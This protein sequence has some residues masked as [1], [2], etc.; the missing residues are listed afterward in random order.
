MRKSVSF[1]WDEAC[2]KAFKDIKE[3]FTKP[4]AMVALISANYPYFMDHSLSALLAKRMMKASSKP[5]ST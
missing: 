5:S 1:V 4:P 3:Y 2:Q